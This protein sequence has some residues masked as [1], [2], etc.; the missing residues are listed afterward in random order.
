MTR[1]FAMLLVVFAFACNGSRPRLETQ[2]FALHYLGNQRARE[3]VDP[4]VYHDRVGAPGVVSVT[5]G[6]LTVRETRDNLERIAGMLAQFDR[7]HKPI[8]LTFHLIQAD[9]A[10]TTDS[11]I[12]DVEAVLRR[13]FRYRGYR[14]VEEGIFSV[15]DGESAQQRLGATGHNISAGVHVSGA[16]DSATV[17]IFVHLTGRDTEFRTQVGVPIG[18]TA[19]L[20][21]VGQDPK[22]TLIL[23]VKPEL[24]SAS[25]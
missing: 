24:V 14:L 22:G 21:N 4:Y 25:P 8:R 23:T 7:P 6:A 5:D 15:N 1:P 3:L 16:G 19:V 12:A 13:L 9:G 17:E 18:K 11:A 10:G 20:G 2:T